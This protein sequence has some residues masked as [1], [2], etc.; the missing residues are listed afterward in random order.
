MSGITDAI[1]TAGQ[2]LGAVLPSVVESLSGGTPS[3]ILTHALIVTAEDVALR[4][5]GA[6]VHPL[7][8]LAV[9]LED[10]ADLLLVE[11]QPIIAAHVKFEATELRKRAAALVPTEPAPATPTSSR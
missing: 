9:R 10:I 5:V 4:R 1:V 11:N 3:S 2:V 7:V 8:V 6:H